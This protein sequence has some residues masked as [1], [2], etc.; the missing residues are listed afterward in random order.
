MEHTAAAWKTAY[1]ARTQHWDK[2]RLILE[3]ASRESN[4]GVAHA[5]GEAGSVAILEHGQR[6]ALCLPAKSSEVEWKAAYE[7]REKDWG[8]KIIQLRRNLRDELL[9]VYEPVTPVAS[10]K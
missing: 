1:E 8:G 4:K 3:E 5:P 10:G 6:R 2:Q 7:A 9:R